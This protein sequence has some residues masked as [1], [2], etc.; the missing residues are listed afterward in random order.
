MTAYSFMK[1]KAYS[2]LLLCEELRVNAFVFGKLLALREIPL[3]CPSC[4]ER[5]VG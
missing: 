1:C 5:K 3:E 2:S 4:N